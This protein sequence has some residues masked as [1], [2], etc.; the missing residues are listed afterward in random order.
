M[1]KM[2][3]SVVSVQ[4][5]TTKEVI[6]MVSTQTPRTSEPGVYIRPKFGPRAMAW[7]QNQP[8]GANVTN[9]DTMED[10]ICATF[11]MPKELFQPLGLWDRNVW[12]V[13]INGTP[14]TAVS[15]R[16]SY[17][18]IA[19]PVKVEQPAIVMPGVVLPTPKMPEA[20]I[21]PTPVI[22]TPKTA[23]PAVVTPAMVVPKAVV[24]APVIATPVVKADTTPKMSIEDIAVENVKKIIGKHPEN[25]IMN[26][27][28]DKYGIM[29][30]SIW[31][32]A[33]GLTNAILV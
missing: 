21:V 10:L 32:R 12:T 26:A 22:A 15:N 16:K 24:T 3:K 30:N 7:I 17:K 27:L 25:L 9:E 14:F 20:V 5:S 8:W 13:S 2:E 18:A 31:E 29:A 23:E 4:N 1:A 33:N 6:N 19:E 11:G 28:K